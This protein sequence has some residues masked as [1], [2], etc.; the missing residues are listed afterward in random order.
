MNR[1]YVLKMLGQDWTCTLDLIHG[2]LSSDV[3]LLT[4]VNDGIL[5]NSGKMLRPILSLCMAH[6]CG[7]ADMSE[8]CRLAA[9]VELIHNATL[10]HDDVADFSDKRRGAP[11]VNSV[12]G[13][14]PAVLVGDFWMASAIKMIM[15]SKYCDIFSGAFVKTLRD[16]VEGEMFQ[17]QKAFS[18][19]TT[20]ED[21]LRIIFCKTASLFELACAQ[22]VCSVDGPKELLE[23]ASTYG[24][25]V[26]Y[27]FQIKD[28]VLDYVGE[29]SGKPMGRDLR[30]RKI[31]LPLIGAMRTSGREDEIRALLSKIDKH[32]ENVETIY[33]FVL[34]NG[35]VE[36]AETRLEDYV[37]RAEKALEGFPDSDY[38]DILAELARY[39]AF[40]EK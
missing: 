30:E 31:T 22:A 10:L 8:S 6:A 3:R 34:D 21:C 17:L 20:E 11:T 15:D 24:T 1:Y 9:S 35:G 32:P 13:P 23:M 2:A 12:Y 27:A 29:N 39:N 14:V 16:L 26:G 7:G 4:Y 5:A 36:Y 33:R 25:A 18:L 37:S 28:D 40:R 38:K 19:D